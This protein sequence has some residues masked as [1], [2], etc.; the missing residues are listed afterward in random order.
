M[1]NAKN[2]L[3]TGP[4]RCGKSTLIQKIVQ[5]GGRPMTGFFTSEI[6]DQGERVGFAVTSLDGGNGT[7]AHIRFRGPVRVGKY[8]VNIQ[9]FERIAIPSMRPS[10]PDQIIVI[11][12][13]GKMECLSRIFKETLLQV[14]DSDHRTISTIALKAD[15]FI[16][17]IKERKDVTLILLT[18]KNRDQLVDLLSRAA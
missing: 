6:R 7:L 13:I 10:Q 4:P 5:R 12:E 1:Q 14:L 15:P 9:E 11:D 3:L 2:I 8:G 17:H 18:E 16:R